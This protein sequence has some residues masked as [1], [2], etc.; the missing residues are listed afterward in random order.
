VGSEEAESRRG[1]EIIEDRAKLR[2]GEKE[3]WVHQVHA[4]GSDGPR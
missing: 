3:E 2:D 4:A 1:E